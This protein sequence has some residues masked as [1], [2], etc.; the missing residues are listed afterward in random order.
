MNVLNILLQSKIEATNIIFFTLFQTTED[1]LRLASAHQTS[2]NKE[3][4]THVQG[5]LQ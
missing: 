5:S 4:S 2:A 1:A 3:A